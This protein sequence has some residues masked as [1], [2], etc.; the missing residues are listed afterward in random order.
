MASTRFTGPDGHVFE[1]EDGTPEHVRRAFIQRHYGTSADQTNSRRSA[2]VS[3]SAPKDKRS[4][5]ERLGDVFSHTVNT[6]FIAEGWR[7]GLDDTADYI[8]AAQRGDHKAAL[9][10]NDRFT[11]NPI[12]LVSRLYNSGGVLTDMTQNTQDTREAADDWVSR[13]RARRQEFAQASRDDPFWEAEGGIVGKTLHGAAALLG[14]LGGAG[15]DPTT[16]IT[17]GT[18]I[19]AKIAVQATVAGAVDL[20]AQTDATGLTQDRYDVLQTVLSAG[21]GAVFTGAFEGVG[22]LAKGRGNVRARID[23]DLRSEPVNLSQ[24]FRDELDTADA[25]SLPALT[26]D[27]WTFRPTQQ[28]PVSALPMRVEAPRAERMDG[29][30][31]DGADAGPDIKPE[32]TKGM[33]PERLKAVTEHLDRLKAFIKPDQ[34]ERFVRWA[35]KEDVNITDDPSPHWNQE[36]FDFDKL[37]NEP[38]KFEEIVGVMAQIFKPLYDA[39]GDAKQSWKSVRD[40]QAAFG[41]TVSDV[42]KAHSDITGDNGIAA[43]MHAL[44]TI[45]I[46]HTDHLVTKMAA[47]E[48]SLNGG[49][50]N[51]GLIGDVAAQLQATVM[52]DAMAAG[53]KSEIGRAL[54]IMK[55]AKQR[56]RILN[57]IQGQMDLMADALGTGDLDPKSLAEALKKLREAY[58]SGGERA[59]KD[60]LRK[61]RHMGFGDYL[62]YYIVAGY[63][64][65]PAT[66]VRNAVGS[67]LHASMTV[68]ERYIAA[69]ITSPLRRGL[70]G[71]R[72]S[73]EGVT[74]REANAYL[75]GIHQSF[76]DATKAGFKASSTRRPRRTSKRASVATPWPSLSSSTPS[77][78]PNGRRAA[79]WSSPT[80]R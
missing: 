67:V 14:T 10:V 50:I 5:G 41:V 52:F 6:G 31:V 28:G 36:I 24:T 53:A 34:V 73:A 70:G 35:G 9:K 60:E 48:K 72:T 79:S 62:S 64:T 30:R 46:Q 2:A 8:E 32:W 66:A 59:L 56:T 16:Y 49:D 51:S 69:G 22:A 63:L 1:F 65:T 33:S 3:L 47:L 11:L 43:K 4:L 75:F 27:D 71:K 54:N 39:A 19:G 58:G 45:S 77:G 17:G 40:R 57:D 18:S 26:R 12:R 68:G 38:E 74:F 21:A 13:E 80:W 61:G 78:R 25:I 55:M 76:V 29:P 7:A 44:E 42:V 15:L 23:A 20:I 37:A